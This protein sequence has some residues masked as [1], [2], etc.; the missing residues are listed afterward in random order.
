MSNIEI[1]HLEH[2]LQQ[3]RER[4]DKLCIEHDKIM[5]CLRW[6]EFPDEKPAYEDDFIVTDGD[7]VDIG[8]WM[9]EEGMFLDSRTADTITHWMPMVLAP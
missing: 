7:I 4:Y 6:R 5:E 2:E 8:R 9:R 1:E 3:L